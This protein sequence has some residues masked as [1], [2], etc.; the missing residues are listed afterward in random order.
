MA[1]LYR[2]E[3]VSSLALGKAWLK[4]SSVSLHVCFASEVI[5][6]EVFMDAF[7]DLMYDGGWMEIEWR[8]LTESAIGLWCV[9]LSLRSVIT[10]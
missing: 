6:E 9:S 7:C 8:R 1:I 4:G 2:E 3:K 5:I 10:T